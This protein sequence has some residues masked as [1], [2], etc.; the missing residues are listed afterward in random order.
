MPWT[1]LLVSVSGFNATPGERANAVAPVF[2]TIACSYAE[3]P[4]IP[5]RGAS[6]AL[7]VRAHGQGV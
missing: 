3:R 1:V 6:V 5:A 4:R 2:Y 7:S